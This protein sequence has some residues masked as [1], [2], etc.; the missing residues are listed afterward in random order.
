[1]AFDSL[2]GFGKNKVASDSLETVFIYCLHKGIFPVIHKDEP[3]G[4]IL[5]LSTFVLV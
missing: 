5:T 4:E 2:L 3:L 1:M